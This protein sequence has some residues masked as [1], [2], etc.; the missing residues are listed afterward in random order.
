[1]MQKGDQKTWEPTIH[2]QGAGI[3]G[4]PERRTMKECGWETFNLAE[5]NQLTWEK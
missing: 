2:E 3:L 1:M 5:R 4:N